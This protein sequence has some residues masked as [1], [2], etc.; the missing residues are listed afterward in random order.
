MNRDS[1]PA[2]LSKYEQSLLKINPVAVQIL[3]VLQTFQDRIRSDASWRVY[4]QDMKHFLLWLDTER[5]YDL[6]DITKDDMY[7]YHAHLRRDPSETTGKLYSHATINRMFTVARRLLGILAE[8][9]LLVN[10][11]KDLDIDKMPVDDET[12]HTALN[13]DQAQRL[14]KAIDA[15]TAKGKRDYALVSLLLRTGLR[16]NEAKM[17][18]IGDIQMDH[19][20]YVATIHYAKGGKPGHVKVPPDVWRSIGVYLYAA[21]RQNASPDAPLFVSFRRGDHVSLVKDEDT[22]Q[23]VEARIDVKAIETLVKDLG[24]AI[25][26]PDSKPLTP[27]GLRASFITL[28]LEHGATL[29]QTQYAARHKDTRMTERYRLR[30][31]NLDNNAVDKLS[32]LAPDA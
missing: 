2:E 12:T 9:E 26:I 14:L 27:H 24:R 20:H 16:R 10:P 4:K 29:E 17:L 32:F 8:K 31:F 18:N 19:G 7:A 30:K 28:A 3:S 6:A 15:S 1:S 11:C 22:G 23:M 13:D 25:G 5:I 21:G